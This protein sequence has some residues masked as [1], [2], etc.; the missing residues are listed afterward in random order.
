MKIIYSTPTCSACRRLKQ[1]LNENGIT[2]QEIM[3]GKDIT[4]EEFEDTFPGVRTVP[5]VVELPD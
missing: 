5:H 2:Y 1:Q 4:Y 3:I